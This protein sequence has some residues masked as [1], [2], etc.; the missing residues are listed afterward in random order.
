MANLW[1]QAPAG[2]SLVTDPSLGW[3]L[4]TP[5]NKAQL[6]LDE[7]DPGS[8]LVPPADGLVP[9]YSLKETS[10]GPI[11]KGTFGEAALAGEWTSGTSRIADQKDAGKVHGFVIRTGEQKDVHGVA[12]VRAGASAEQE[13]ALVASIRS[14]HPKPAP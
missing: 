1:I 3:Q 9:G 11:Q 4:T 7:V 2:W 6:Y 5:D 12:L 10:M 13:A 14:L 8:A